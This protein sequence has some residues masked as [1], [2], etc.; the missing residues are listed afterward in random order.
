MVRLKLFIELQYEIMDNVSDFI[1]NIHAA[2]TPHQSLV[3]EQLHL[4]Q[5]LTPVI[6]TDS[7]YG[8]R[9]M[10]LNAATGSLTVRYAAT[11]DIAHYFDP[12]GWFVSCQLDDQLNDF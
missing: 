12:T 9:Y 5:P 11:V 6:Y 7:M 8:T 1:F 2:Q 4:S 10:R 3:S